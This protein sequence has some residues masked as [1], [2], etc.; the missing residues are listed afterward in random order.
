MM[1]SYAIGSFTAFCFKTEADKTGATNREVDSYQLAYT[2][3]DDISVTYGTETIDKQVTA[4]DEE[5]EGFGV[6]YTTGGMTFQLIVR[7]YRW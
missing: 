7:S 3:S 6:S 2:V 4:T 5:V 1:A